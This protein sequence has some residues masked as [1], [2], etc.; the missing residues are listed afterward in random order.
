MTN[1]NISPPFDNLKYLGGVDAYSVDLTHG[2]KE[3]SFLIIVRDGYTL[4]DAIPLA[5]KIWNDR[6]TLFRKYSSSA[7]RDQLDHVNQLRHR[8]APDM[9]QLTKMQLQ[10]ILS[11]PTII[12]LEMSNTSV[13]VEFV[14]YSELFCKHS[15]KAVVD[16]EDLSILKTETEPFKHVRDESLDLESS[17]ELDL[18][19]S[20]AQITSEMTAAIESFHGEVPITR[21]DVWYDL[22]SMDVPTVK[23]YLDTHPEGEPQSGESET[24]DL[25]K[26]EL[27]AWTQACQ[28]DD[29]VKITHSGKKFEVND[30][31]G[32]CEAVGLFLVDVILSLRDQGV[33]SKLPCAKKCYIGVAAYDG[34]WSWPKWKHRG[35]NDLVSTANS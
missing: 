7:S 23:L 30:E 28:S 22:N 6:K 9:P 18:E 16:P 5:L 14:T 1:S 20:R 34:V 13:H 32:L 17:G 10:L 35:T 11:V 4:D 21:V 27:D 25:I 24:F 29:P 19:N 31:N 33:L 2:I 3:V 12:E 15:I 8:V 26:L